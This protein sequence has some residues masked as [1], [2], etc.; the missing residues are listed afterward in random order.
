MAIILIGKRELVALVSLSFLCIVSVVWLFLTVP[1][2]C[3][4]FV[5][6]IFSDHIHLLYFEKKLQE[7][8]QKVK[9]KQRPGT[10]SL[11]IVGR[12][13][14][15]AK[16]FVLTPPIFTKNCHKICPHILPMC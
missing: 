8:Y 5:I 11:V 3:L 15:D 6:V 4:Q 7:K 10:K 16:L 2:V 14:I 13:L 12:F 1:M 9:I